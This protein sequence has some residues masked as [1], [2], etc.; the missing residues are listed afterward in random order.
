[1]KDVSVIEARAWGRTVGAVT[2][3][4]TLAYYAFEYD[5]AWKRTGVELAPL[6]MPLKGSGPIYIFPT[7]P[8]A[9]YFRLPALLADALPDDF[10]NALIDAWMA[11][12]GVEKSAI[13]VLDRLAYMGKRGVGA[14]EFRPARGS[15]NESS[16]PIEMKELVEEAR[17]LVQGTF[18][19][20]HEAQ[21][22]LANIIKVGTSAGGARAKAVIAWNPATDE[23]RSGQF[24]AAPGFEHWLLKF[25]GIGKDKELGTGEG[26]GRIEFAYYL[27]AT[28]AGIEMAVSRLLEE[29]GRAHFM[30]RR[31]DREVVN[32]KTR[33][34]HIQT[35]CAM[36][37]LDFRQ[38]G[39]HDYAQLFM[40]AS[41]LGL[42]DGAL[43]QIFRRMAF[44]VMAR[45]CDD[46][47]KNFSFILR[48]GQPWRLAPAYDVTHAY[49]PKG[50]WTYQHLMS[51]NRK[52]DGI[53]KE[54]LLAVADR[55]SVRRPERALSEVRA[56]IDGWPQ[57]AKQAGL[58][59]ALRDR[60]GK[61]LLPL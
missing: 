54:D 59:A 12:R 20:D 36:N 34:H 23:V 28:G 29:N 46:H 37:H 50:E 17:R 48:E 5:P 52:F 24:D 15:H 32:G 4:P 45:N 33:K 30:T 60:V 53:S 2:L 7:L 42:D 21:A 25:D 51:V 22:A 61:D 6:H 38:R 43:D 55:F 27:M 40:T 14:L 13:T 19:V 8:E 39:T 49:N 57:F 47:T 3:D 16:A 1:M 10:G 26:Y 9:T 44:N 35:L 58:S 18:A 31:F 56:A 11:Q 41:A